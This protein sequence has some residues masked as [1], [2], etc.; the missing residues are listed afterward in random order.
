MGCGFGMEALGSPIGAAMM[1]P[2]LMMQSGFTPKNAGDQMTRSASWPF[3]TEPMCFDTPC[4]IAG[5]DGVLRD[6]AFHPHIVVVALFL[7]QAPALF[8]HLVGGLP[9]ADDHFAKPA[10]GLAVRRHHRKRAE[11]V[12]DIFRRDRL[13]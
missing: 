6:V 8:L 4:A 10:H 2:P 3:S 9:G 7:R 13:L 11:V 5:F 1:L 12:E